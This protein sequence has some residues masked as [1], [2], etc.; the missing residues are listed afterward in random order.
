MKYAVCLN[1]SRPNGDA[2]MSKRARITLNPDMDTA[3]D[4][5]TGSVADQET[6]PDIRN[7]FTT[8]ADNPSG[9]SGTLGRVLNA[10]TLVKAVFA[11]LAVVSLVLLWKNKRP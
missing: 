5:A 9:S 11:G 10:G 2:A 8:G 7:D 6:G 3:A 1:G 4:P